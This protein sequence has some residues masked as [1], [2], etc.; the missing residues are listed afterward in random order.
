MSIL[1]NNYTSILAEKDNCSTS[2]MDYNRYKKTLLSHESAPASK[3]KVE[4]ELMKAVR[5]GYKEAVQ[6]VLDQG[7]RFNSSEELNSA[8]ELLLNNNKQTREK[9]YY[10]CKMLVEKHINLIN[11]KIVDTASCIDRGDV[12]ALLIESNKNLISEKNSENETA[13]ETALKAGVPHAVCCLL[14]REPTLNYSNRTQESEIMNFAIV[15]DHVGIVQILLEKNKKLLEIKNEL[16]KT[17]LQLAV[18]QARCNTAYYFINQGAD[19]SQLDQNLNRILHRAIIETRSYSNPRR[20][21]FFKKLLTTKIK[22]QLNVQNAKGETPFHLLNHSDNIELLELLVEECQN[23]NGLF[24]KR[25]SL[26]VIDNEGNT[27]LDRYRKQNHGNFVQYLKS[28]GARCN[29]ECREDET[30]LYKK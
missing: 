15:H 12:L 8:F 20:L 4:S 22:E 21:D 3:P 16:N 13:L 14:K 19:I 17:P 29:T 6:Q 24:S 11:R 5:S 23:Q 7:V 25:C 1:F 28:K 30:P 18:S 10:I 2:N 26:D 27:P 9:E